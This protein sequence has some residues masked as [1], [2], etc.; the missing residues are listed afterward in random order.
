MTEDQKIEFLSEKI[1]EIEKIT[2]EIGAVF[3]KNRL[4]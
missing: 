4:N 1:K 2:Q 3:R